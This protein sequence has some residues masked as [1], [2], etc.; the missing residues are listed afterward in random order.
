MRGRALVTGLAGFTGRYMA[1]ELEAL[2][3]EVVGLD[4]RHASRPGEHIVDLRNGPRLAQIVAAIQP[5]VVVHLAAIA[6][7]AHGDVSDLYTSNIVGSRNLLA[8][9][10]V[11]NTPAEKVLLASSANVYGNAAVSTLDEG[12]AAQPENDYAVSKYAM[13]L[14][15]RQWREALPIVIARPFNYTGVGQSPNFLLPKLVDHFARRLPR[16]ELGNIDVY[17]DFNDVRMVA[18]AYAR[19][20]EHGIP[21]EAYNVCSGQAYSIKDVLAMLADLAGYSIEVDVNP[22]FVRANEVR[23]L[24]GCNRKLAAAI[25]ELKLIP[26]AETLRWMYRAQ[27]GP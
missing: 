6:F 5:S 4:Q 14:L 22:A 1:R 3:Y 10:A 19:L 26:L 20:L 18:S 13:E 2:G 21:G 23:R 25:G 15:A 7:V 12:C 24:V 16:V 9:L 27:T 11:C 8:A 17:R